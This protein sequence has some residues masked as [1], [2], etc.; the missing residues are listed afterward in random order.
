MVDHTAPQQSPEPGLALS[1]LWDA[2]A[3]NEAPRPGPR[4]RLSLSAIVDAAVAAARAEGLSAVTMAR[5]AQDAGCAKMALYRHVSG[6]RDLLTAM[7]DDTLGGPPKA[8]GS[9]C[10]RFLTLWEALLDVYARDPWLL[11]LPSDTPG[12]TPRNV[13]WI[14]TALSLFAGST[15]PAAERLNTVLLITENIRFEARRRRAGSDSVDDLAH[16]FSAASQASGDLP[17]EQFPHL[18]AVAGSA[19]TGSGARSRRPD[20][21]RDLILRSISAYFPEE[22]AP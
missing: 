16:L 20:H 18:A 8:V 4:P 14:D 13:A 17:P 21:V 2:P 22:R 12:L 15:L 19:G 7:L 11:E 9:W 1:R 10:E 5:V 3:A 6:H